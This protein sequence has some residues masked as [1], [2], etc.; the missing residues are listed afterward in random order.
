MAAKAPANTR[1]AQ[2]NEAFQGFTA[3]HTLTIGAELALFVQLGARPSGLTPGELAAQLGLHAPYVRTWCETAFANTFLDFDAQTD[4]FRLGEG[5]EELLAQPGH[6]NFQ[7]GFL[8]MFGTY[9]SQEFLELPKLFRNGQQSSSRERRQHFAA[10]LKGRGRTR[11]MLFE[12]RVLP[13]LPGLQERLRAGLACLDLGCGAGSF[14]LYL[15]ERFP[16]CTFCGVDVD[17]HAIAMAQEGLRDAGLPA[18]MRIEQL[19]GNDLR[20]EAAFDLATL[21]LV[22]H[23]IDYDIRRQTLTQVYRALKQPGLL[24]ILDFPYPSCIEEFR[25]PAFSMGVIDQFY[26]VAWGSRHQSWEEI[27][28]M[29]API[30]FGRFRREFLAGTPYALMVAEKPG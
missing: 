27:Q 25:N 19:E 3:F 6:P 22:L 4:R 15:A 11:G 9:F 28:A 10:L 5:L 2:I 14:L 18:G 7:G 13:L 12:S 30:G 8:Q 20:Y 1:L 23:E 21:C 29:L 26:E 16:N 17:P 24:A